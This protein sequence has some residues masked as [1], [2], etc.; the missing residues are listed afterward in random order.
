V[1]KYISRFRVLLRRSECA[2]LTLLFFLG[3]STNYIEDGMRLLDLANKAVDLPALWADRFIVASRNPHSLIFPSRR[4]SGRSSFC[5]PR[6]PRRKANRSVLHCFY[7]YWSDLASGVLI[8]RCLCRC[9]PSTALPPTDR[10]YPIRSSGPF[11][12]LPPAW[13][14]WYRPRHQTIR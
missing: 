10:P 5:S 11:A 6:T 9:G 14:P 3:L 12:V 2:T 1:P 7:L 4:K 8:I 13:G